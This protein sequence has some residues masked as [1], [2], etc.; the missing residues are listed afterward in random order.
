MGQAMTPGQTPALM[1]LT[2]PTGQT[3][4]RGVT[5]MSV[6]EVLGTVRKGKQGKE[7]GSA[8]V[9]SSK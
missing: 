1:R 3:V 9:C 7:L 4:S 8:R 2:V 5:K 6:S